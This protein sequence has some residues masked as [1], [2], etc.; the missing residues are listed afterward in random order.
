[1]SYAY[2]GSLRRFQGA[3]NPL[4]GAARAS[5][6]AIS[7]YPQHLNPLRDSALSSTVLLGFAA[8]EEYLKQGVEEIFDRAQMNAI[9]V[10]NVPA[11]VRAHVS[12]AAHLERWAGMETSRLLDQLEVERSAGKFLA[13]TDAGLVLSNYSS[14]ILDRVKYP[15]PKNIK[16]LF[17]RLGISNVFGEMDAIAKANTSN[18]LTSF[19]DARTALAHQGIPPGWNADDFITK[20]DEL[21]IVAKALDR[22]MWRWTKHNLGLACWPR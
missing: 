2:S 20:L 14:L 10:E 19:H 17:K 15:K 1:M 4:K 8:F 9:K 6:T 22:V 16:V 3:I 7:R 13:L 12:I 11:A 18:L 5:K 21:M